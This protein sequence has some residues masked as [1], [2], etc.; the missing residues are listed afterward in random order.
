MGHFTAAISAA[1]A[2]TGSRPS[3]PQ[4]WWVSGALS[5]VVLSWSGPHHQGSHGERAFCDD[6]GVATND[7]EPIADGVLMGYIPSSYSARKLGLQTTGNAAA[8]T[9]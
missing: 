6:E 1:A 9:T 4:S 3:L 8:H 7:R 2:N 5:A